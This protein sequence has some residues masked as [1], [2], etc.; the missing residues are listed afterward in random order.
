MEYD[1]A[2]RLKVSIDS[3]D[4]RTT[5]TYD[6]LD[7]VLTQTRDEGGLNRTTAYEYDVVGR[8]ISATDFRGDFFK[9]T[10]TLLR[11]TPSGRSIS[12]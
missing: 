11:S 5:F 6:E 9:T 10:Y 1:Q 7:R 12:A 8:L 4:I 3:N 2:G